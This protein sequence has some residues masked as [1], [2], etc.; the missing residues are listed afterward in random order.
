MIPVV[1]LTIEDP[2]TKAPRVVE[3]WP[4]GGPGA[5]ATW[6]IGFTLILAGCSLSVL[7][8][9]TPAIVVAVGHSVMVAA[10]L[11]FVWTAGRRRRTS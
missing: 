9:F 2:E 5:F 6:C 4:V 11:V 1:Q 7:S 3:A 8:I 10:G